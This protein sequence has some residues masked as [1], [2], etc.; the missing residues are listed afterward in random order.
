MTL[1][2]SF[3]CLLWR[4]TQRDD[5]AVGSLIANR[6]HIQVER[7]IGMFANTIVLRTDLSGDPTF[8]ELLQR[9]RHVTLDAYRNQDLPFE[10][11]LRALHVSRSADRNTLFQVMF[12]LQNAAPKA[13]ALAGLETNF[14]DVDTDTSQFDLK[15]ELVAADGNLV[16]WL[17]YSTDLFE[18]TTMMHMAS[19]FEALLAA[20][21]DNPEERISRLTLLSAEERNRVLIDWNDTQTNFGRLRT[22]SARFA[23]QAERTPHAIAVSAGQVRLS[24]RELA[25]RASAIAERLVQEGVGRDVVVVLLAERSVDF[26]AAMVGVQWAGGAFLPLNPGY[27]SARLAQI[28]RQSGTPLVLAG[29]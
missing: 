11:V 16:G 1:L 25:R 13:P 4:Y 26:L 6:N 14:V 22:F 23:R 9:V 18:A 3:V 21:V 20:I 27:P 15:L 17:E 7:L 5:I 2:A 12:V 24:Y 10:E 19:N 28:V 29:R 8:S